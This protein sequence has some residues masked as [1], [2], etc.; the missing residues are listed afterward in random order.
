MSQQLSVFIDWWSAAESKHNVGLAGRILFG[1]GRAHGPGL[2]SLP[3]FAKHVVVP[4]IKRVVT[5]VLRDLG[6]DAPMCADHASV[7]VF[8]HL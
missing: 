4:F 1:F 3:K 5:L 8:K 7:P 6:P 2:V